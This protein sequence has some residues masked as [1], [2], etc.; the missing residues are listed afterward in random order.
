[1][2]INE[3]LAKREEIVRIAA[4]HGAYNVRIFGSA[5]RGEADAESDIDI[6]VDL[7]P[8]RSLLDHAALLLDLQQLLGC[9]VD[10]VTTPGLRERIRERVL[11]EAIPL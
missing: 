7:E 2:T 1:M 6:L 11:Q 5:A 3:I 10:V 8:S 9:K 4:K